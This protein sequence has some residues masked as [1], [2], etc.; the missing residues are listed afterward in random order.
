[1]KR[2]QSILGKLLLSTG[3]SN[4]EECLLIVCLHSSEA[5]PPGP[6]SL[7]TLVLGVALLGS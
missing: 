3:A 5:V 1:M 4:R 2:L 6:E 7:W